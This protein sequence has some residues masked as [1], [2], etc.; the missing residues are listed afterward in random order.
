MTIE[1]WVRAAAN[2]ADDGQIVAKSNNASGW[3]LKTSPD[4]GPQTFGIAVSRT[5]S[6]RAQRYSSTVRALNTWYHVAG[7]YNTANSTLN[8]YVNGALDNGTILGTVGTSQVN[9]SVNVNIGRRTGGYYFNGIIDEVRIY[10]RALTQTE[11]QSDMNTP[12]GASGPDTQA[13]TVPSNVTATAVSG[14]QVNLG[15]TASTDNIAVTGYL[16]ERCQGTNCSTFTQI[17]TA[18]GTTYTDTTVS[19]GNSYTYRIR[20]T[21][22]ANNLSGYSTTASVTTPAPDTQPPTAPGTPTATAI[23]GTQ[24]NLSWSA[25]NDNVGVTGYLVERCQGTGCST[26][27]Q[28]GTPVSTNYSDTSLLPG[29]FYNYRV[30]AA[31]AAGNLGPYSTASGTTTLAVS[32]G[33][34]A[35]YAFDEGSGT[36][37]ADASGNGMNGTTQGTTWTTAGKNGNALSFNGSSGYVDLGNPVALQTTGSM[38]WSAWVYATGNP[39]DDGQIIAKSQRLIG[40]AVQNQSGYRRLKHSESRFLEFRSSYPALQ[41]GRPVPEHLV[42]RGGGLQRVGGHTGHLRQRCAEQWRAVR[43]GTDVAS[44]GSR[45]C[46]HWPAHGWLLFQRHHR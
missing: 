43:D 5:S 46:E 3:Q 7:V 36:T 31:D 38:T 17:G 35:A 11:I 8:I 2:P 32:S 21:D 26:F 19:A 4:T 29:T 30:R 18:A 10:N 27:S 16:I 24:I 20:A 12:L 39:A 40:L 13:P 28:I 14:S 37:T 34:L 44:R 41:P 45:Q 23:S 1:A 6:A 42:S 9:S 33:L 15:W 22:A 25:A